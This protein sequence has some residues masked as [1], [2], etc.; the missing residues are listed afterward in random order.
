MK[1]WE[2][3]TN[4]IGWSLTALSGLAY[5][6]LKYFVTS[7]DPD[8]RLSHPWRS[9]VLALHLLAAPVAVF[10]LGLLFRRHALA[11]ISTGERDGRHSGVWMTCIAIPLALSGYA[12]QAL[13]GDAER[14]WTG[15]LHAGAGLL[16]AAAYAVHPRRSGL[17]DDAAETAPQAQDGVP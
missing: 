1:R 10:G 14:R 6:V 9:A 17:P 12:V 8:S 5:G 4:H 16:F 7:P 13:T 11:R 15:W 2:A 3:R